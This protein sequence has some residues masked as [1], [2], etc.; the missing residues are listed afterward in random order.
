MKVEVRDV[1]EGGTAGAESAGEVEGAQSVQD[2]QETLLRITERLQLLE[3]RL[4]VGGSAEGGKGPEQ[5]ASPA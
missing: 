1:E 4:G 2:L 5:P 3:S